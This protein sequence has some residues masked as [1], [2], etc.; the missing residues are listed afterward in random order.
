[1][2]WRSRCL[3]L[4]DGESHYV[5]FC[6]L[7]ENPLD[8]DGPWRQVCDDL[9]SNYLSLYKECFSQANRH[10]VIQTRW[11]TLVHSYV[12][13]EDN[14]GRLKYLSG[15]SENDRSSIMIT[16]AAATWQWCC[17][18]VKE[19]A[20]GFRSAEANGSG[21][22]S[23]VSTASCSYT[24]EHTH[25]LF[26]GSVAW[27]NKSFANKKE[28]QSTAECGQTVSTGITSFEQTLVFCVMPYCS[29]ERNDLFCTTPRL[30]QK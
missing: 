26:G 28:G 5:I 21:T 6:S 2:T 24:P 3:K 17:Q 16:I 20:E 22:S 27:R 18:Q 23:S 4:F 30:C 12:V 8:E 25:R 1:M 15:L 7:D 19:I 10:A 13:M 9:R 14:C 29:R 11:S